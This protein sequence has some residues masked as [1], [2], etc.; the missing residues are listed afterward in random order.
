M[1]VYTVDLSSAHTLYELHCY[2]KSVF[3]LPAYYGM[4]MDALWDCL[5]CSFAEPTIIEV[6]NTEQ[7]SASMEEP[8]QIFRELLRDLEQEN[9]EVEISYL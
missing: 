8:V 2:L 4:N 3:S 1:K 5:H 7:V 9:A 6:K